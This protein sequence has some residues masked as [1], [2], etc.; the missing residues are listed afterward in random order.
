MNFQNTRDNK[1]PNAYRKSE[2]SK[3]Q[4][5]YKESENKRALIFSIVILEK[6]SVSSSSQGKF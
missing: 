3:T 1:I 4:I 2:E 6:V 5:T